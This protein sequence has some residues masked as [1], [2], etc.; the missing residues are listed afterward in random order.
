MK[1][2]DEWTLK[3]L[4]LRKENNQYFLSATYEVEEKYRIK[5][6]TF[7][8]ILL[9]TCHAPLILIGSSMPDGD[10]CIDMGFGEMPVA[11]P[12]IEKVIKEKVQ[13]LT[14]EEIEK[15]LG[16]KVK[17]VHKK[18]CI[19][20]KYA[21]WRCVHDKCSECPMHDTENPKPGYRPCKCL[22]VKDGDICPYFEEAK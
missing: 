15:K 10:N 21:G 14:L 16:H 20:C 3:D 4:Q 1:M 8:K 12:P 9:P 22:H 6:V 18:N 11:L 2:T 13:E 7:P 5:E 19:R 17:V